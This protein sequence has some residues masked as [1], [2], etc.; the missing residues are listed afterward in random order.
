MITNKQS[1]ELAQIEKYLGK[2]SKKEHNN[3]LERASF[4][5]HNFW[6][7]NTSNN[8][9]FV[10]QNI[11]PYTKMILTKTYNL[12]YTYLRKVS[13][14]YPQVI[15]W[16]DFNQMRNDVETI[17]RIERPEITDLIVNKDN[18][19]TL[20]EEQG[21]VLF[22][23]H[24]IVCDIYDVLAYKGEALHTLWKMAERLRHANSKYG[25]SVY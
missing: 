15:N 1:K 8:A 11:S 17:C 9:E 3:E 18:S 16:K 25:K 24:G 21:K 2:L 22:M 13:Y 20:T 12:I 19:F 7:E 14:G 10:N 6:K 5:I 4:I 23:V